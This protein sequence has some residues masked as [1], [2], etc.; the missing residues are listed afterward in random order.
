[1]TEARQHTRTHVDLR[2]RYRVPTTFEYVEAPCVDLSLGGM[3]LE[4]SEPAELGTLVK[5]ECDAGAGQGSII[6]VGRVVW[7]RLKGLLVAAGV[8]IGSLGWLAWSLMH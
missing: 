4:V 7:R 8:A 3:F 2:R 1:M 6:G 5:I